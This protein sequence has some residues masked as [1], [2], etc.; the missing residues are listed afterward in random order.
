MIPGKMNPNWQDS[1][2]ENEQNEAPMEEKQPMG[3]GSMPHMHIHTHAKGHTV[4]IMH[5]NGKHEKHEHEHG[6]AEGIA[7]HVHEHFVGGGMP[8]EDSGTEGQY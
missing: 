7:A 1:A 8:Q 3:H 6:D 5:P 4:H 2:D